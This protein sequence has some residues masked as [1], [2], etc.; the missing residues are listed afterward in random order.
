MAIFTNQAT[1]RYNGT[2][3]NSNVATGELLAVLSATKT[4]VV[5][6]YGANGEVTYVVSIVNSGTTAF[7]GL[8]VTDTL[9][10][11]T[12]NG[13]TVY[14]LDYVE[15]S[16]Q[17]YVNGVLQSEPAVTADEELIISGINVPA[18][19]NVILVYQTNVNEFAPLGAD[20]EITNEVSVSGGGITTPVVATETVTAAN[21]PDLTI[22]KS[23]SP[24]V[25]PEN[26]RVTYT[27][28]IQ[29]YGNTA[30][31]ESFNATVTDIFDPILTDIT[32]TFNG[33]TW[34]EGVEYNYDEATGTFVTVPGEITVDAATFTQDTETGTWTV[35]PGVSVLTVTGTI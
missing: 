11:Y 7:T 8:V 24:S 6:E 3:R 28:T 23:I 34:T 21:E 16:L 17:Y 22:N 10:A 1:L 19:G 18:L 31:D 9:G 2:V 33:T 27:F 26:S 29:N 20:G 32:V 30:A 4:A 25:V 14:P 35:E 12:F 15:G 5:N 13:E